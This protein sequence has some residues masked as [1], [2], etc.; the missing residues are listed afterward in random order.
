MLSA[1]RA[2]SCF[3]V[4][5]GDA[6]EGPVSSLPLAVPVL[7]LNIFFSAFGLSID[8]A[9][10]GRLNGGVMDTTTFTDLWVKWEPTIEGDAEGLTISVGS[11]CG[12][13]AGCSFGACVVTTQ[14]A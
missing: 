11:V 9:P 10:P 14:C 8:P 4:S 2:S 3:A 5:G 1:Q 12:M 13:D 6:Y 7:T